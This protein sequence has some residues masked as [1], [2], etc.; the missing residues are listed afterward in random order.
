MVLVVRNALF[1][2]FYSLTIVQ[3]TVNIMLDSDQFSVG[4]IKIKNH[5][6]CRNLNTDLCD[7]FLNNNNN[8]YKNQ[9]HR[10]LMGNIDSTIEIHPIRGNAKHDKNFNQL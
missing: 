3:I 2:L 8:C 10:Y 4:I 1:K 7:F 9:K 6:V 5:F